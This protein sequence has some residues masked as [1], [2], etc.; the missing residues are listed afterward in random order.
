MK[1][2][3][4][5]SEG[6]RDLKFMRLFFCLY[7][8]S[9]ETDYLIGEDIGHDD[10]KKEESE[11]LRTMFSDWGDTEVLI[12]SE[13]G[14]NY[15]ID[16]FVDLIDYVNRDITRPVFLVDL[17]ISERD[18]SSKEAVQELEEDLREKIESIFRGRSLTV[19][20]KNRQN[21][22]GMELVESALVSESDEESVFYIIAFEDNLESAAGIDKE[23]DDETTVIF[24]K[25][26]T[27]RYG[28]VN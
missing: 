6:K 22:G 14:V 15:L 1:Q 28:R 12:K 26:L 21:I 16:L 25:S 2:T 11:R 5:F 9:V 24:G 4:I 27:D 13:G 7:R 8:E 3:I 19:D 10:L 23:E 20:R 18:T 17:D